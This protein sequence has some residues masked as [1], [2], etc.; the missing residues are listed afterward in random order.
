MPVTSVSVTFFLLLHRHDIR[1]SQQYVVAVFSLA[2]LGSADAVH[3]SRPPVFRYRNHRRNYCDISFS[4]DVETNRGPSVVDPNETI[5]ATYHQ[6]H[7]VRRNAGRPCV[8]T[9]V[10]CI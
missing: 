7:P 8:A 9:H 10:S 2:C 1:G 4:R 6:G 3:A 5:L